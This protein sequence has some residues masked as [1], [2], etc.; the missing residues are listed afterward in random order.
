MKKIWLFVIVSCFLLCNGCSVFPESPEKA[1][2]IQIDVSNEKLNNVP[3]SYYGDDAHWEV[4]CKVRVADKDESNLYHSLYEIPST[5]NIYISELF[6]TSLDSFDGNT[7]GISAEVY[8]DVD[9]IFFGELNFETDENTES[10]LSGQS[11]WTISINSDS[12]TNGTLLPYDD[13]LKVKIS[14]VSI[15][16]NVDEDEIILKL[17]N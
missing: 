11:P 12:F 5:E 14:S 13:E 2:N 15:D 16:N 9:L 3:Y 4:V 17:Q 8:H 7:K 10:R 6:I 1:S